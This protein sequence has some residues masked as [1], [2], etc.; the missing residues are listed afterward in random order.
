MMDLMIIMPITA[1]LSVVF[2][3]LL[4]IYLRIREYFPVSV[5]CWFC[6]KRSKVP[7]GDAN[8]WDCKSCNQYNG[9]L[10]DGDYNRLIPAQYDELLN[11]PRFASNAREQYSGM[12]S[13]PTLCANCNSNQ[14]MKIAQLA[15]FMPFNPNNY[16]KEIE[17]Y[18]EQLEKIYGICSSC[19]ATVAEV[20]KKQNKLYGLKFPN[21]NKNKPISKVP[22]VTA[23][24]RPILL[25]YYATLLLCAVL[26]YSSTRNISQI[27]S[28]EHFII[29]QIQKSI[30]LLPNFGLVEEKLQI[31]S[32]LVMNNLNILYTW[33]PSHLMNYM[34]DS[35][36]FFMIGTLIIVQVFELLR[37]RNTINLLNT[38]TWI[39]LL[40]LKISGTAPAYLISIMQMMVSGVFIYVSVG[41]LRKEKHIRLRLKMRKGK[42]KKTV[43]KKSIGVIEAKAPPT[44]LNDSAKMKTDQKNNALMSETTTAKSPSS[45]C[46]PKLSNPQMDSSILKAH[47]SPSSVYSTNISQNESPNL[48]P[49]SH[50]DFGI[51]DLSLGPSSQ[52]G[53]VKNHLNSEPRPYCGRINDH[54]WARSTVLSPSRLNMDTVDS[55]FTTSA[56]PP[57]SMNDSSGRGS[58]ASNQ[59]EDSVCGDRI[60][61]KFT[62]T[63]KLTVANMAANQQFTSPHQRNYYNMFPPSEFS[64]P[65]A[66]SHYQFTQLQRS[67]SPPNSTIFLNNPPSPPTN[68]LLPYSPLPLFPSSFPPQFPATSSHLPSLTEAATSSKYSFF[69]NIV[70]PA[71]VVVLVACN[72]SLLGLVY[73]RE[74]S[75]KNTTA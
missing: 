26:F 47:K 10:E 41:S 70:F 62:P 58:I 35:K 56:S 53:S 37:F 4:K 13:S 3:I 33:L 25:T 48:K 49:R 16:D 28:I 31:I 21:S 32:L 38:G 23:V 68:S 71:L 74:I 44:S 27:V 34:N 57:R 51:S 22:P 55:P 17:K 24:K 18:S 75:V 67:F 61:D 6:C 5:N 1:A 15:M 7:F 43:P 19:E 59:H 11:V 65:A 40:S 12:R 2:L 36:D 66:M 69:H 64:Y 45:V 54:I 42:L 20:M 60:Y 72:L 9:F 73:Y 8:S 30:K 63:V 50:N 39:I 29:D 14:Q 52:A 46:S